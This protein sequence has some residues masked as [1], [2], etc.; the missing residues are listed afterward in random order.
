MGITKLNG[1]IVSSLTIKPESQSKRKKFILDADKEKLI[2][3]GVAH[4]EEEVKINPK[5]IK[6][7][8]RRSNGG[9]TK[10]LSKAQ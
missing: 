5:Q 8:K 2:E 10:Y 6:I 3:L 4:Y 9:E 7:N 1:L